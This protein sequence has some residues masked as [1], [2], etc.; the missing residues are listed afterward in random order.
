LA[1]KKKPLQEAAKAEAIPGA[2][3]TTRF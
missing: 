3:R 2:G 1:R